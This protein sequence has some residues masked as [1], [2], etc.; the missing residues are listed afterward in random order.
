MSQD[1]KGRLLGIITLVMFLLAFT[2]IAVHYRITSVEERRAAY[3]TAI[4]PSGIRSR[5]LNS[6]AAAN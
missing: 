3:P 5:T 6:I 2:G 1:A 4:L